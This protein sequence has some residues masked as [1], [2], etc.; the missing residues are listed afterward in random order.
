MRA[1]VNE[2][3]QSWSH[4]RN[5]NTIRKLNKQIR[6][7]LS[8]LQDY[9]KKAQE[10]KTTAEALKYESKAE[11]KQILIE[12]LENKLDEIAPEMDEIAKKASEAQ[13]NQNIT[14]MEAVLQEWLKLNR[15]LTN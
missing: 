2:W 13:K 5:P 14:Q 3:V 10:A 4:Q 15:K 8:R 6:I 9:H 7:E 11:K 12:V 1:L